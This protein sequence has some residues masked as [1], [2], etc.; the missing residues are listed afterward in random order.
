VEVESA[1]ILIGEDEPLNLEQLQLALNN[2]IFLNKI[3]IL[4]NGVE[5]FYYLIG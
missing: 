3:D 2:F 5:D 1:W 4:N